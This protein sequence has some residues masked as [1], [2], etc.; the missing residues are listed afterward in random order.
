VGPNRHVRRRGGRWTR[1]ERGAAAVEFALISVVLVPL[2]FG[3]IEY[4]LWFNDSLNVRQGVREAARA[5]VVKSFDYTGCSGNDMAKLACKT[6]KEIGAVTGPTYVK[7]STPSGWTKAQPLVVC[8]MVKVNA[9][10]LVPLPSDNLIRSRTE[11]SIEVTDSTPNS[12]SYT[13][14]APSGANWSWC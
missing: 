2:V 14:T 7:I 10:G 5:G 4:G 3:I 11:M 1:R 6:K 13:D 8:A 12:L 9:P